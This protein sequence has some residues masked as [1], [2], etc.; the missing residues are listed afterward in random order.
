MQQLKKI[1]ASKK[2]QPPLSLDDKT[3]FYIFDKVIKEEFGNLGAGKFSADYFN[4]KKLFIKSTSSAW[5]SE[6]WLNKEKIRQKI[7]RLIGEEAVKEIKLK[8]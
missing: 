8:N 1:L 6:L 2:I 4:N 3:V 7:N 5:A